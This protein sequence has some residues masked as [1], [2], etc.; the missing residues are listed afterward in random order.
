MLER[1]ARRTSRRVLVALVGT[2]LAMAVAGPA[3]AEDEAGRARAALDALLRQGLDRGQRLEAAAGVLEVGTLADG[4]RTLLAAAGLAGDDP[5]TAL[6]LVH[7]VLTEVDVGDAARA[8]T[9][10]AWPEVSP[11]TAAAAAARWLLGD[12]DPPRAAQMLSPWPPSEA[13]AAA[14]TLELGW[15]GAE[16]GAPTPWTDETATRE[17]LA[18]AGPV[19]TALDDAASDEAVRLQAGLDRLVD[20]LCPAAV[21]I[22]DG[23]V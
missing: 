6:W 2:F 12:R 11:P 10:A 18:E 4:P 7:R 13:V 9:L 19:L 20:F 16:G 8:E 21:R 3:R 14:L 5:T 22:R 1:A 15:V 17:L 23:G